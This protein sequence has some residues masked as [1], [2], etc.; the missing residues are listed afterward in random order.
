MDTVRASWPR[1]SS[2]CP[3]RCTP[4]PGLGFVC[5]V[6]RE[7]AAN[8]LS[9]PSRVSWR[10]HLLTEILVD[11]A[12]RLRK[13]IGLAALGSC[14]HGVHLRQALRRNDLELHDSLMRRTMQLRGFQQPDVIGLALVAHERVDVPSRWRP[15]PGRMTAVGRPRRILAADSA[16]P[17][18]AAVA[19][20]HPVT[21]HVPRLAHLLGFL[22]GEHGAASGEQ[23]TDISRQAGAPV[24]KHAV[25]SAHY[26]DFSTRF[27]N[28]LRIGRHSPRKT[29]IVQHAFPST[30][31]PDRSVRAATWYADRGVTSE[32]RPSGDD[33]LEASAAHS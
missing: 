9:E 20:R 21:H 13:R 6:M 10:L 28:L 2:R 23:P 32:G 22:G 8:R 5:W 26:A 7:P 31:Y 11:A 27:S 29:R 18:G 25:L 33:I 4:F 1:C 12:G 24:V 19:R 3:R 14:R 30:P 16:V 17:R 15:S